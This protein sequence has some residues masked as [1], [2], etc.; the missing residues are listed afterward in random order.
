[1]GYAHAI[2]ETGR[3]IGYAVEAVC[4]HPGCV[5]DIHRGMSYACGGEPGNSIGCTK[6]VCE[7][8]A[9]GVWDPGEGRWVRMCEDCQKVVARA[10]EDD[11]QSLLYAAVREPQPA[12]DFKPISETQIDVFVL[13]HF[14][15]S[16][17]ERTPGGSWELRDQGFTMTMGLTAAEAVAGTIEHFVQPPMS[18][19]EH[20]R[21]TMKLL[22]QY[23]D[24]D[25]HR[26]PLNTG[27]LDKHEEAFLAEA[28]ARHAAWA[29]KIEPN[30]DVMER[31]RAMA[32]ERN[33]QVRL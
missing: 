3:E 27:L 2:D 7:E 15:G 22:V 19:R 1:M 11:Y 16:L 23:N 32:V 20:R 31:L 24:D 4:D 5:A 30:T 28:K 17:V 12:P 26:L 33:A 14:S 29:V 18:A 6:F 9:E 10:K 13:G 8:H 25:L 21:A